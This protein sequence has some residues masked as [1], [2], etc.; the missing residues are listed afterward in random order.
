[1]DAI[2]R[3]RRAALK[4]QAMAM[5]AAQMEKGPWKD[6]LRSVDGN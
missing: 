6:Y 1:M 5:R 4:D 2:D 3:H